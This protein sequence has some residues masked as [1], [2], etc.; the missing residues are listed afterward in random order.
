MI[1]RN[2]DSETNS[3]GSHYLSNRFFCPQSLLFTDAYYSPSYAVSFVRD[4][5]EPL[6]SLLLIY[7][8]PIVCYPHFMYLCR[9][10]PV[11]NSNTNHIIPAHNISLIFSIF[12]HTYQPDLIH[13]MSTST[14]VNDIAGVNKSSDCDTNYNVERASTFESHPKFQQYLE[15]YHLHQ[16][17]HP[18]LNNSE[19]IKPNLTGYT[20]AG[21]DKIAYRSTSMYFIHGK[22]RTYPE[23]VEDVTDNFSVT[24]FYLGHQLS[25]HSG[26]V[27]G[28]LLAT[29]LDELTCRLAFHNLESNRGVTANLN[30][31]YKQ[32][33]FVDQ[34]VMFKCVVVKKQGRKCWV[35]GEVYRAD[36]D[37][38]DKFDSKENLLAVC[39]VLVIEPKWQFK[40]P[41]L[42]E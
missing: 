23:I 6:P 36:L 42:S 24:F 19:S 41:P 29:L 2:N 17:E 34:Y 7:I 15:Q 26:I 38:D 16:E 32:P 11:L 22:Y 3:W 31:D 1:L 27:H 14:L 33:T 12:L 30:I 21:P 18:P 13:I 5:S 9:S 20:L 39:T 40:T 25:G 8:Y 28:G 10:S 4:S 37:S 35:R